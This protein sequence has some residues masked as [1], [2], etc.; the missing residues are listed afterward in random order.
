[1]IITWQVLF[2]HL[3]IILLNSPLRVKVRVV[4][5]ALEV[6]RRMTRIRKR[7]TNPLYQLEWG[8]RRR[9]QRDQMLPANCPW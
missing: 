2:Q 6:A 7:N 8:R 1:M 9:K 5:M 4:V 3:L